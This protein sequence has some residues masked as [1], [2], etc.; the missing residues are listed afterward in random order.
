MEGRR[1]AD[2][3]TPTDAI[4][5]ALA[6]PD[7]WVRPVT[8]A[9][10]GAWLCVRDGQVKRVPGLRGAYDWHPRAGDFMCQWEAY[11]CAR[12]DEP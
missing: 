3:M 4:E 9:G 10:T 12:G 11:A 5:L 2:R 8:W 6:D 1:M 7:Q